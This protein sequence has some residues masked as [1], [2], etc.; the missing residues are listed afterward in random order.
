MVVLNLMLAASFAVVAV[1]VYS[2]HAILLSC[3]YTY[4]HLPTTCPW[5]LYT[6]SRSSR[7]ANYRSSEPYDPYIP[8]SGSAGGAGSSSA[9]TAGGSQ[10]NNK[11]NQ[12]QAQ[13]DETVGIMHDNM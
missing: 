2:L 1:Q 10:G 6:H 8:S 13:I 5:T 11:I 9:P 7:S 12:I 3:F 4:T